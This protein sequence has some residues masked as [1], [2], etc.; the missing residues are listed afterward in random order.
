MH[1]KLVELVKYTKQ[2]NDASST[3]NSYFSQ[4][5]SAVQASDFFPQIF[6]NNPVYASIALL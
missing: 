4:N 2:W 3:K 1:E 6:Q 5:I